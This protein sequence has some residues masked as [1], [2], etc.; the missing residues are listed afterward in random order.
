MIVF[1]HTKKRKRASA[2]RVNE[3][4]KKV[5]SPTVTIHRNVTRAKLKEKITTWQ[6]SIPLCEHDEEREKA[7]GVHFY[8]IISIP[9]IDAIVFV[10]TPKHLYCVYANVL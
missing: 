3:N 4:E 7:F 2:K 9:F 8:C 10:F 1:A 5:A 6:L